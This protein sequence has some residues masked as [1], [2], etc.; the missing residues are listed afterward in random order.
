[1]TCDVPLQYYCKRHLLPI[2]PKSRLAEVHWTLTRW[3]RGGTNLEPLDL[4]VIIRI[5]ER[6][7]RLLRLHDTVDIRELG[8]REEGDNISI[9]WVDITQAARRFKKVK[10]EML[11]CA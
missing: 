2:E 9:A 1:M 6:I 5:E 3:L 4:V 7:D 8:E 10:C 11:E